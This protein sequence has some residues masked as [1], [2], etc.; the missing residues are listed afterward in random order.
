MY[1]NYANS[2][3]LC[4]RY[5]QRIAVVNDFLINKHS[6]ILNVCDL[7]FYIPPSI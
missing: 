5:D 2:G 6:S 4:E 1:N 3:C 7:C